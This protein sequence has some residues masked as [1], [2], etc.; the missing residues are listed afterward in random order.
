MSFSTT[1]IRTIERNISSDTVADG[2]Y[3]FEL[4]EA[5]P[6]VN[7]LEYFYFVDGGGAQV[8][9]TAGTVVVTV[10]SGEDIFQSLNNGSFSAS[11]AR[12]VDRTKPN[13]LGRA[14]KVRINLSGVTGAVG[15]RGLFTQNASS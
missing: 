9:A 10:S 7:L 11:A 6:R 3:D 5:G 14:D 8:D 12:D 1:Y 13:G 4:E 15:F 2:D